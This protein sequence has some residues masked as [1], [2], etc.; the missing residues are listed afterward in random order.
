MFIQLLVFYVLFYR[1]NKV[2]M[3]SLTLTKLCVFSDINCIWADVSTYIARQMT[4]QKVSQ[5]IYW[6]PNL[7]SVEVTHRKQ[8]HNNPATHFPPGWETSSVSGFKAGQA[9]GCR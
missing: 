5:T 8:A 4:L 9:T 1:P 6:G 7:L 3:C 2:R